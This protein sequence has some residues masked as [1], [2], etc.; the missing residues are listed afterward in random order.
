MIDKRIPKFSKNKC[1]LVNISYPTSLTLT[2]QR[3]ARGLRRHGNELDV[4]ENS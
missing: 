3:L 1:V 2:P 4:G